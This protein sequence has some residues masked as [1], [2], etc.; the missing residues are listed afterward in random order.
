M[1]TET[2]ATYH[3]ISPRRS[4][5]IPWRLGRDTAESVFAAAAALQALALKSRQFIH[6]QGTALGIEALSPM[7]QGAA[8]RWQERRDVKQ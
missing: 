4:C 7:G 3:E 5:V 2:A 1:R 6:R 8:L